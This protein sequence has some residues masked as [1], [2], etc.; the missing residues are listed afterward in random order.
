MDKDEEEKKGNNIQPSWSSKPGQWRIYCT[1]ERTFSSGTKAEKEPRSLVRFLV[2]EEPGNL[3]WS[4]RFFLK[5]FFVFARANREAARRERKR[6]SLTLLRFA[7]RCCRFAARSLFREEK[8]QENP[9]GPGYWEQGW[10]GNFQR[11][12]EALSRSGSQS[13]LRICFT[14]L[15]RGTSPVIYKLY[16]LQPCRIKFDL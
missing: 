11:T 7:T 14:L 3:P 1:T 5:F 6:F 16:V 13:E 9:L 10:A 2:G 15:S 12:R 4:Q 8:F